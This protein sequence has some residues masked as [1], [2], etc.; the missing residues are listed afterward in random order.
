MRK[1][2]C[3]NNDARSRFFR[4][5]GCAEGRA[6]RAFAPFFLSRQRQEA[7]EAIGGE[8]FFLRLLRSGRVASAVV[9]RR[10]R[11]WCLLGGILA[12]DRIC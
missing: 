9:W 3:A 6:F 2:R 4:R 8:D 1:F 5:W 10:A 7:Q 11:Q 12:G